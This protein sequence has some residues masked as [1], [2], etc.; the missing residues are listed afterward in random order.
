MSGAVDL[1][2]YPIDD[3]DSPGATSWRGVARHRPLEIVWY[4]DST[5][6]LGH[7]YSFG[8]GIT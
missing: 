1:D 7:S 2:R 6:V 4:F 5:L 8:E 3:L